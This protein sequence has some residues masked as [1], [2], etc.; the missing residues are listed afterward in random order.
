MQW[1][2]V[3]ASPIRSRM[4]PGFC[5]GSNGAAFPFRKSFFFRLFVLSVSLLEFFFSRGKGCCADFTTQEVTTKGKHLL[6]TAT[7]LSAG[8]HP[9]GG[10]L[11]GRSLEQ[12]DYPPTHRPHRR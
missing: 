4:Q 12:D 6:V 10:F 5:S 7:F 2:A 9:V 11:L 3:Q 8:V 1:V